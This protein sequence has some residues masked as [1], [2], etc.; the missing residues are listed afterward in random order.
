MQGS[1]TPLSWSAMRRKALQP[2]I[3]SWNW[4]A[5]GTF[6]SCAVQAQQ[7]VPVDAMELTDVSARPATA[8]D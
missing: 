4:A 2:A 1:P 3:Q 7:P 6:P 8:D 5:V